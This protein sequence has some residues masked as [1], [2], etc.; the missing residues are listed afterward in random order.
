VSTYLK[1][2]LFTMQE[3]SRKLKWQFEKILKDPDAEN[4]IALLSNILS[5][6]L[7][8]DEYTSLLRRFPE[9]FSAVDL[10]YAQYDAIEE[11]Y[12]QFEEQVATFIQNSQISADDLMKANA[13]LENLNLSINAMLDG[14]GQGLLFFDKSGICSLVHSKACLTLLE[15]NPAGQHIADV[16]KAKGDER[17]NIVDWVD[18]VFSSGSA[19][20][21]DDMMEIAPSSY[22]HSADYYIKL[23]YRPL[24]DADG[25]IKNILVIATD[26]TKEQLAKKQV[27]ENLSKAM[28]TIRIARNRNYFLR[29]IAQF[30]EIF[31]ESD[32]TDLKTTD[33]NF[34]QFKRD[35]HTIKGLSGTF[36]LD[37]LTK[38]LHAFESDLNAAEG[39]IDDLLMDYYYKLNENFNVSVQFAKTI[40]G[41]EFESYGSSVSVQNKKIFSLAD[42]IKQKIEAGVNAEEI[43][44]TLIQS[45]IAVPVREIF[46]NFNLQL[47]ELADRSGKMVNNCLFVGENFV[48]LPEKYEGVVSSLVHVARN[49]I[50]HAIDEPE[51][52]AQFGKL[53]KGYITV[54]TEKVGDNFTITIS[55]DGNGID[56]DILRIKLAERIDQ[57]ELDAKSDEELIQHIFDDNISTKDSVSELSGRGVGMSAVKSEVEKLGG[58]VLVKSQLGKGTQLHMTMPFIWN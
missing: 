5:T 22:S 3:R 50:D 35:V 58:K 14:L 7:G 57:R 56:T 2:K 44:K 1:E 53:P 4:K 23:E 31:M 42:E 11:S 40:L 15:I 36:H 48:V 16:L 34:A 24:F 54:Q 39:D 8:L 17:K 19:L 9:F 49:I 21:F 27:E 13:E 28:A 51:V 45:L 47:Q 25:N 20:S 32:F 18:L 38:V 41:T 29:F 52:R 37:S 30:R 55:D 10:S 12:M 6:K 33:P 46:A 43:S 26:L